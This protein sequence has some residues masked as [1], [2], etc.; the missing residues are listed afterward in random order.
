VPPGPF[1]ADRP[2]LSGNRP[3]QCGEAARARGADGRTV[4]GKAGDDRFGEP[5]RRG[6][7]GTYLV[8][9]LAGGGP[10]VRELSQAALDQ[11]PQFGGYVIKVRGAVDQ[12]VHERGGR[13][14][15]E[16]SLAGGGE[17]EHR[18]QAEQ[19]AGRAEIRIQDLFW[20]HEPRRADRQVGARGRARL[21]G[22]GN[23]EVDDSRPVFGQQ[24]VG[25]LKVAV[26]HPGGMDGAQALR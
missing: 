21:G 3:G 20:G 10:V 4:L 11:L 8:Q 17:G 22:L 12:P 23:P 2:W 18:A 16:R 13:P 7:D 6:R 19:V 1:P 15:T 24:D 25:R 14:G 26:H 5:A 9:Q